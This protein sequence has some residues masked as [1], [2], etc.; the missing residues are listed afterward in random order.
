MCR[1]SV[2]ISNTIAEGYDRKSDPDFARF[3]TIV[4]TSPN[5]VKSRTYLAYD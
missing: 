3:L 4:Q 2:F 1:A 5:A